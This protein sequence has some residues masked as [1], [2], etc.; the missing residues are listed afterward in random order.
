MLPSRPAE[1]LHQAPGWNGTR[2]AVHDL[3]LRGWVDGQDA[4]GHAAISN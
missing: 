1:A 3:A 2:T 4:V